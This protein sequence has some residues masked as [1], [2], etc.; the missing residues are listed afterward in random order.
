MPEA[1]PPPPPTPWEATSHSERNRLVSTRKLIIGGIATFFVLGAI[2]SVTGSLHRFDRA[3]W[4]RAN[5]G[6]APRQSA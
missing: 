3:C 6:P 2:G 5:P 1:V 4:S